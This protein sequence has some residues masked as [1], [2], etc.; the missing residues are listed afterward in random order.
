M[1]VGVVQR[2]CNLGRDAHCFIDGELL[3][4]RQLVAQGFAPHV[5]QHV[6]HKPFAFAR[7]DEGENVRMVELRADANLFEESLG[8]EHR[9]ELGAEHLEGHF[10]VELSIAG[11]I[12]CGHPALAELAL[13]RVSA[14]ES[15]AETGG[16]GHRLQVRPR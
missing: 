9:G 15:R 8:T 1:A 6:P 7:F 5:G 13:D 2:T 3:L 14:R 4:A 16:V 12:D 10:A 11:E